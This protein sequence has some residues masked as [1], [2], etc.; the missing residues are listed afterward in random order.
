MYI[1]KMSD[2]VKYVSG[3]EN[4]TSGTYNLLVSGRDDFTSSSGVMIKNDVTTA[5]GLAVRM[6]SSDNAYVD[7]RATAA[8]SLTFRLQDH[9]TETVTPLLVLKKDGKTLDLAG[10][11]VTGRIKASQFY[12]GDPDTR[13]PMSGLVL[14]VDNVYTAQI[15][16]NKGDGTGGFVFTTNASDGSIDRVNMSLNA[17]GTVTIPQYQR[18]QDPYDDEN[19]AIATF[20]AQ[21]KLGRGYQQNH[22]F[23]SIEARTTAT[24]GDKTD[25]AIR[26]NEIIRRM[27]SLSV[28]STDMSEL[29]LTPGFTFPQAGLYLQDTGMTNI[30]GSFNAYVVYPDYRAYQLNTTTMMISGDPLV[31]PFEKTGWNR[32]GDFIEGEKFSISYYFDGTPLQQLVAKASENA[33]KKVENFSSTT[34]YKGLAPWSGARWMSLIEVR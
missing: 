9:T 25:T 7:H 22:R 15:R 12:L 28:F 1:D 13:A 23:Q 4:S 33:R 11:E 3:L 21:G 17:N 14:G 8:K 20:D 6:D 30:D 5:P 27:N 24:E 18:T 10:A 26:I 34:Q 16:I 19:Y 29:V 2:Y 31:V 32:I